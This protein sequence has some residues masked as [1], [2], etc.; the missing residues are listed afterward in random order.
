MKIPLKNYFLFLGIFT[1]FS[2]CSKVQESDSIK[3]SHLVKP[4]IGK[5]VYWRHNNKEDS[6]IQEAISSLLQHG[7]T[8]DSAI[9]IS[10]LNNKSLQALY[11]EIGISQADLIQAGL[12]QNPLISA[13]VGIPTESNASISTQFSIAQNFIDAFSVSL[14]KKYA[15]TVLEQTE[16]KIA[17]AI[18]DHV[19]KVEIAFYNLQAELS[20]KDLLWQIIELE[21][22]Q[23]VLCERQKNAGNVYQI[24]VVNHKTKLLQ[25]KVQ[26]FKK[27]S[28]ILALRKDLNELMGLWQNTTWKIPQEL[29]HLPLNDPKA[30]DLESIALKNRFDLK[31]AKKEVE[32]M[33]QALGLNEW[34]TY[35][36]AQLGVMQQRDNE[37]ITGI[38]PTLSFSIPIFD[39]GQA[40]RAKL[41]SKLKKSYESMMALAVHIRLEVQ[42]AID[43]LLASRMLAELYLK[44]LSPLQTKAVQLSKK[45]YNS[46]SIG[47]YQLLNIK[48]Q[49]LKTKMQ[50]IDALQQYWILRVEL[51]N[52]VGGKLLL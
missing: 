6:K 50:Y 9:Q 5:E 25:A 1:V 49:E 35:T 40:A 26:L 19:T 13:F 44:E 14:R 20:K 34:W 17:Q 46:M 31:V 8:L 38:G 28:L 41:R 36:E 37:G 48:R 4:R 18:L 23:V 27:E 2:S 47:T 42:V 15:S 33:A 32:L 12:L 22:T 43:T 11:E 29:P 10:L 52:K 39:C 3:I 24:N 30:T 51:G 45:L 21:K 7:L 16:L